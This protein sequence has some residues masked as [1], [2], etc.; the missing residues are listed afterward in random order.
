ML[1][2]GSKGKQGICVKSLDTNAASL[3]IPLLFD[4]DVPVWKLVSHSHLLWP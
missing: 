2:K 3:K 4:D 1:P